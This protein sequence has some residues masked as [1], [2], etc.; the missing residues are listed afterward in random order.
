MFSHPFRLLSPAHFLLDPLPILTAGVRRKSRQRTKENLKR[1]EVLK[2]H[3]HTHTSTTT[4][5]T[6][7]EEKRRQVLRI[8]LRGFFVRFIACGKLVL[9]QLSCSVIP[10]PSR[11]IGFVLPGSPRTIWSSC[12]RSTRPASCLFVCNVSVCEHVAGSTAAGSAAYRRLQSSVNRCARTRSEAS[13]LVGGVA[14][15]RVSAF[16]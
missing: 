12:L 4:T 16:D 1:R 9:P 15:V 5:T 10:H 6:K 3:T 14:P 7:E 8:K 2:L 13:V 11:D